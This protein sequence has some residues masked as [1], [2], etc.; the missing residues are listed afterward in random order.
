LLANTDFA[1]AVNCADIFLARDEYPEVD[2][3]VSN[4]LYWACGS[5]AFYLTHYSEGIEDIM[6]PG[7]EIGTFSNLDEMAEKIRFYID[8]PK[9][10]NRIARAGQ[11]RV[12]ENYT[13]RHR[14]EEMFHRLR[15]V[16]IV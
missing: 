9:T 11:K 10:R 16:G 5:G 14:F 8:H 15:E 7:R 2:G 13:F 4:W 6:V 1:K 12:L 3:S